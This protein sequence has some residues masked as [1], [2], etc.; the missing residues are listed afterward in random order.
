MCA[1]YHALSHG[2]DIKGY[3]V[4]I[5]GHKD[6]ISLPTYCGNADTVG[7]EG[8]PSGFFNCSKCLYMRWR[9]Y[10]KYW[11]YWICW[12][13]YRH[14]WLSVV[15]LLILT[16]LI[17]VYGGAGGIADSVG[18]H[19]RM[20]DDGSKTSHNGQPCL[21]HLEHWTSFVFLFWLQTI[22]DR[23]FWY[24]WTIF[25]PF[26]TRI[27]FRPFQ[28]LLLLVPFWNCLVGSGTDICKY[29]HLFSLIFASQPSKYCNL[30][31]VT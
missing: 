8:T 12:N 20:L 16:L 14:I 10:C 30:S 11:R 7:T 5:G 22:S 6:Y 28:L 29:W 17:I 21:A 3:E 18:G 9:W 4:Q 23:L 2:H 31:L 13:L 15:V 25:A 24:S 19:W 1:T 27:V 26:H